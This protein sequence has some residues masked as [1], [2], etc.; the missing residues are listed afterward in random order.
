[1]LE[2]KQTGKALASQSHQNAIGAARSQAERYVKG[3]PLEEVEH[4]RPPF[5]VV[6]DGRLLFK[7]EERT[8]YFYC[9]EYRK[10]SLPA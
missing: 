4:G 5:V 7:L 6:V 3:L 10:A 8:G 9:I 1:M 2:G